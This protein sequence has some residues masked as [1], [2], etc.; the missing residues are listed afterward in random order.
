ML[1]G[2]GDGTFEEPVAN[3]VG[4]SASPIATGDFTGDGNLGLAVV[5]QGSDSVTILPGN[6]DGTFQPQVPRL[7]VGS[8][9]RR[10]SWRATSTATAA[11]TWPSPT[12]GIDEV[13]MLLGNGDGTFQPRSP[14]RWRASPHC[15]RR[16]RLHGQRPDRPGRGR[17]R[18]ARV[19]ILLGNGDGTFQPA[20]DPVR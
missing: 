7:P 9:S 3:A 1:L 20:V 16:G 5:N 12:A 10:R 4:S 8:S 11:S 2:K 15:D 13:S 19:T 17:R 14:T 18:R 6:G